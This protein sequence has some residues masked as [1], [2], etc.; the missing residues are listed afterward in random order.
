MYYNYKNVSVSFAECR[1][2]SAEWNFQLILCS[3]QCRVCSVPCAACS[4]PCAVCCGQ[5]VECSVQCTV[6]SVQ[7]TVCSTTTTTPTTL[8]HYKHYLMLDS[9][10][11][12]LQRHRQASGSRFVQL[13][14]QYLATVLTIAL[15]STAVLLC[16]HNTLYSTAFNCTLLQWT[17][18]DCTVLD[19]RIR[20]IGFPVPET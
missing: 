16:G 5:C 11:S 20:N 2:Q 17:I 7:C 8:R 10:L 4:V 1:L 13:T 14:T 18:L 12:R 15:Y 6:C 19:K 3:V 9:G